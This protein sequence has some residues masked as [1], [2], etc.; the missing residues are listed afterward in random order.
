MFLVFNDRMLYYFLTNQSSYQW[1]DTDWFHSFVPGLCIDLVSTLA[2]SVFFAR[3]SLKII[4]VF[5][6]VILQWAN[7]IFFSL[8]NKCFMKFNLLNWW[9]ASSPPY[10]QLTRHDSWS[11]LILFMPT[12]MPPIFPYLSLRTISLQPRS[13]WIT[14]STSAVRAHP[15]PTNST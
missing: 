12:W 11:F 4:C 6:S 8:K 2:Q 10:P 3:R 14:L 15:K 5:I 9:A 7:Y 13:P 1:D